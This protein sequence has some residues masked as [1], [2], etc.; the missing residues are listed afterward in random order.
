[1]K[2]FNSALCT[3]PSTNHQYI[4]STAPSGSGSGSTLADKMGKDAMITT[5]WKIITAGGFDSML[6]SRAQ[7]YTIFA[8][9]DTAFA[10]IDAKTLASWLSNRT[11]LKMLISEHTIASPCPRRAKT[12]S[13][14]PLLRARLGP[15]Q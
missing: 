12:C 14:T 4:T 2:C 5:L 11:M 10:A 15:P 8:P 7:S 3:L 9:S 6:S 13:G 1:M